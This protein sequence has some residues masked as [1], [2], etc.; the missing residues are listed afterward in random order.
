MVS[1]IWL[2]LTKTSMSTYLLVNEGL[3]FMSK[4]SSLNQTTSLFCRPQS[5]AQTQRLWTSEQSTNLPRGPLK[6]AGAA[7]WSSGV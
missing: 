1:P 4:I 2:G 7:S 6:S 3:V 5:L